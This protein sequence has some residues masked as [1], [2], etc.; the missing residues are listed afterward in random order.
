MPLQPAPTG[1]CR[2]CG[3]ALSLLQQR[4]GDRCDQSACR[5]AADVVR[6]RRLDAEVGRPALQD[7]TARLG[8]VPAALL[9]LRDCRTRQ[10]PVPVRRAEAHRA[11]G[12]EFNPALSGAQVQVV[13][14]GD[15]FSTVQV[16][17]G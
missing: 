3:Q 10:V 11:A 16:T 9:W 8:R 13:K 2:F 5:H 15:G 4:R 1:L 12:V 7:S 6:Q 17:G 14:Q